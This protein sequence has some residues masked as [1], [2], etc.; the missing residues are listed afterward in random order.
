MAERSYLVGAAGLLGFGLATGAL[1]TERQRDVMI[2]NNVGISYRESPLADGLRLTQLSF[3]FGVS[4][5]DRIRRISYLVNEKPVRTETFGDG[6][7][8]FSGTV[9]FG[10]SELEGFD[11]IQSIGIREEDYGGDVM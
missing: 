7:N 10:P 4:D 2:I 5:V 1:L 6:T 11:Q 9:I 8:S 3:D